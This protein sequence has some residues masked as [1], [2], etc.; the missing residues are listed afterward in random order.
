[1]NELQCLPFFKIE[2][3]STFQRLDTVPVLLVSEL[4]IMTEEWTD[5]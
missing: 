3:R 2:I 1:M 4:Q 5:G